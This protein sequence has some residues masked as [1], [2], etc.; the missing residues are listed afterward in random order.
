MPAA[1]GGG[2]GISVGVLVGTT[3][4]G[5][6][7]GAGVRVGTFVRVGVGVTVGVLVIVGIIVAVAVDVTVGV[8]VAVGV[9]LSIGAAVGRLGRLVG[10]CVGVVTTGEHPTLRIRSVVNTT[11][12][13]LLFN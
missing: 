6:R 9:G 8:L 5:R 1:G 10:S 2:G 11:R 7:V 13:K 4:V 12:R 3:R